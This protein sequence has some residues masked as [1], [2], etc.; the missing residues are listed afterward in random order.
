MPLS[1]SVKLPN[2]IYQDNNEYDLREYV[3][4]INNKINYSN[5]YIDSNHKLDYIFTEEVLVKDSKINKIKYSNNNQIE[6]ITN[7][8]IKL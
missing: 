3:L 7:E 8:G 5:K 2:K 4:A 1:S 6:N